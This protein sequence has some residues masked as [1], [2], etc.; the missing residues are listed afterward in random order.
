MTT[1]RVL[2]WAVPV[3]DRWHAIGN[4]KVVMVGCRN[5]TAGLP[6]ALVEVWTEELCPDNWP[7]SS[8]P[9]ERRVTVVGT[10]HPIPDEAQVHLGS[11]FDA[12]GSLVWHL[13][14]EADP[15]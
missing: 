10:G 1:R 4:G 2:R 8:V 5:H 11:V 6:S 13:Y 9:D 7:K 15:F 12:G 3:D 14:S